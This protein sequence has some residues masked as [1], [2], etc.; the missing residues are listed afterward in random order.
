MSG[1]VYS[2]AKSENKEFVIWGY[3]NY[4]REVYGRLDPA[5]NVSAICDSDSAKWG[6]SFYGIDIV[7]I[8]PD[9]LAGKQNVVVLIAVQNYAVEMQIAKQL[10]E[11]KIDYCHINEAIKEYQSEWEAK[12]M[13]NYDKK[14]SGISEPEGLDTLKCFITIS[15]PIEACN[16]RCEYCYIGQKK[17]FERKEVL[18]HSPQFIRKALSRKRL[19]GTALI[20]FCGVGETLMCK[21]I[22]PILQELLEEGHYISIITN[23]LLTD[24]LKELL[25]LDQSYNERLFFK[26][27][28]HYRQLVQKNLLGRYVDNVNLIKKS[29]ASFSVEL[30]PEDEI[31][32]NIEEIKEFSIREFGA[33]PHVTV[34]R[35]ESEEECPI[36]SKLTEEEYRK[37]WGQF[38]SPMFDIKMEYRNKLK[39]FCLAGKGTFLFSL[40]S[41]N[42]S[43]CPFHKGC[44]NVYGN[45]GEVIE[46]KTVGE[47]CKAP[48]CINAHAYLTLG[49]V[50]AIRDISYLDVR[51]RKTVIG[52]SWVRPKMANFIKQRICDNIEK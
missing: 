25:N 40:E 33:L 37:I 12:E 11:M 23:A 28:F 34:A 41:G 20:N 18:Y 2:A 35:D 30:V 6:K 45:I 29:G 14:F 9:V 22:I 50:A 8:S 16:L 1:Q 42:V 31:I 19:G 49:M 48:Y 5:L 13:E 24:A 47:N 36:L 17:E 52:E 10:Q 39:E 7:C 46:F 43:P 51:D 15:V 32:P 44:G 38:E 27:S 3:G 26:C 21:E 4:L